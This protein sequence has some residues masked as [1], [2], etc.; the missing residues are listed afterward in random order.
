MRVCIR[1]HAWFCVHL[2]ML[3]VEL[4]LLRQLLRQLMRALLQQM[5]LDSDRL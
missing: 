3:L 5:Y 4:L 1:P 2:K